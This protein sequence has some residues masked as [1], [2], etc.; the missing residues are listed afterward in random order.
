MKLNRTNLLEMVPFK[1]DKDW[2]LHYRNYKDVLDQIKPKD[3]SVEDS[4]QYI[5][6]K[7]MIKKHADLTCASCLKD[8]SMAKAEAI[9]KFSI[10]TEDFI[11]S[12]QGKSYVQT[13]RPSL[14]HE[15]V[16]APTRDQG[17]GEILSLYERFTTFA[18]NE[19]LSEITKIVI[20][21]SENMVNA[22]CS[23][24]Q[25]IHNLAHVNEILVGL[26]LMPHIIPYI[27]FL[28][29]WSYLF[30]FFLHLEGNVLF[31]VSELK[32]KLFLAGNKIPRYLS[33]VTFCVEH[34][35]SVLTGVGLSGFFLYQ[36]KPTLSLIHFTV[37]SIYKVIFKELPWYRKYYIIFNVIEKLKL[38]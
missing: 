36:A 38:K 30:P 26:I 18:Q 28:Q 23:L 20:H 2:V 4:I 9:K 29:F 21:L 35:W 27:G 7:I 3:I 19:I 17:A 25:Q 34:K 33:Y 15:M 37:N 1:D 6:Y 5:N 14:Y 12:L 13:N 31:F 11:N 16:Y 32:D 8:K 22:T 10:T 24:M